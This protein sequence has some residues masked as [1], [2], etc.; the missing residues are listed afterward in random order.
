MDYQTEMLNVS[1]FQGNENYNL[2]ELS[3]YPRKKPFYQKTKCGI[4]YHSSF[5][6]G[7]GE[8]GQVQG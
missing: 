4:V 1:N 7:E 3:P 5:W 8:D 6:K 2:S